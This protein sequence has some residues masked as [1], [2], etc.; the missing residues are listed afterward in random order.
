MALIVRLARYCGFITPIVAYGSIFFAISLAPWFSWYRNALSDLGARSP[1]DV[2]FN[3]GLIL[4]GIL[5]TI[6]SIGLFYILKGVLGKFS[7]VILLI[8]SIAL[9]GIGFFPETAGRIHF[10]FSVIFFLLYPISSLLFGLNL[11]MYK[12]NTFFG[13]LSVIMTFLC[14]FIWFIIPWKSIGVTGVAIPEFLSSLL[15]CIWMV[16]IAY[17]YLKV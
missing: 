11:I 6:F 10:Y 16:Y 15:G 7:A 4:S 13:I 8:D 1:S 3:L 12:S 9:M 14:F 17:R 2:Y 5:V